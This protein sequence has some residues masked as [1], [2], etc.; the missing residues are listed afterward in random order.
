[1]AGV[2]KNI[3]D[4]L[5]R[6][7]V[8]SLSGRLLFFTTLFVLLAELVIYIPSAARHYHDLLSN[9]LANAQIAVLALDELSETELSPKLKNELLA[10]AGVR[11]VALKRDN[12]RR[13]YLAEAVPPMPDVSVDLRSL[14]WPDLL[15]HSFECMLN[16]APR[17]LRV[18]SYPRLGGGDYID[19][20]IDE[21]PVRADLLNYTERLFYLSLVIAFITSGLVFWSLYFLFVRPMQ[22]VSQ[23][24][25]RFQERPEDAQRIIVPT[26][27]ADEIGQAER[28]LA[29]MQ[30][31][32]RQA[33]QQREHLAALGAAVTRIQHDLRNIL[34]TAQLASDRLANSNDPTVKALAPR[35]MQSIDRA[36]TLATNTLKYGKADEARPNA[37]S[38]PLLPLAEEA[39]HTALAAGK[40]DVSWTNVIPDGFSIFADPDQLLRVIVNIG[41]N[42]VQALDARP[43]AAITLTA[44]RSNG[45]TVL[46]I[47]D[48]GPGLPESVRTKLFE[49][50]SN[51][52][53]AGGSGLGLAIAR[54]LIRAH[55]GD[56]SLKK[57]DASGT[58]F[59]ITMPSGP[60]QQDTGTT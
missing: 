11:L 59:R 6:N 25:I 31:Q 19:I 56:V 45:E 54:E 2:F 36:I 50:F 17:V 32:L 15:W 8:A 20:M 13:L 37:L 58:V 30:T 4:F 1:M 47:E 41:R 39:M 16:S 22:R 24:M 52:G 14:W 51:G 29:A 60:S 7:L 44:S 18:T 12:T 26:M 42:A 9:K 23:S 53:R 34:T 43:G 57:S 49:P 27:R 48:N 35:L 21:A 28:V 46:D 33:L 55:G 5:Y 40:N 10:N 38:Q 3:R